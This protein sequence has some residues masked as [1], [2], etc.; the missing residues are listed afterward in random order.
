M[1]IPGGLLGLVLAGSLFAADAPRPSL[2]EV[3]KSGDKSALRDLLQKKVDANATEA[4]GTT[5][6]HW[7]AY[8]D[9]LESADLLLRAGAKVNAASDLG[10]T[11]L[12]AASQNGSS[13][14]VKKLLDAGANPNLAL[15]SGETPL[16]V[17]CRSGYPEAVELL[18]GKGANLN[19]HGTRGQTA[20]MWAVAQQHADVVKVLIAHHVDLN[21]KS[22]SW[23]DVMAVPPHGY[24]PY[25]I[26]VPQGGETALMFAARVGDLAS[27]KLL[28]AAGANVNDADAWGV[29]AVTLAE[30]S[31]FT[32]LGLF[33]L[34]KGAN[35]NAAPNGFTALHEAIM[36]RDEKMVAALLDHKADANTPL[37]QWTPTRR[38]SD[39]F[40]FEPS[41]VGA[42]PFWLAAR[43]D[44]P[45]IMRMLAAHGADAKV[46]FHAQ[47]VGEQ[48]FGQT[49]RSETSTALL[50]ATGYGGGTVKPWVEASKAEKEAQT[51]EAV[52]IAVELGVDVNA[53]GEGRTALD[54][55]NALRYR[56]VIDFLTSKG[57]K[58]GAGGG[59]GGRG[60]GRG[61]AGGRGGRG[62]APGAASADAP[63]SDSP[64]DEPK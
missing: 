23:T 5:A 35:P 40:H 20:L 7:A 10:A 55:A 30:H 26:A 4:D 36:R 61:A 46:V 25:N 14:M 18:I 42:T 9:D 1:R 59:R 2:V 39:D 19:A 48:G 53:T 28:I 17:A 47:W 37:K 51:L 33:L 63:A 50:A 64:N 29:S 60:G 58:A 57:A 15:L 43:F 27:A 21:L 3:A 11:P 13:A 8:R 12:W 34:D 54:G 31:G 41:L 49:E 22:D 44:E 62:A 45:A 52:K 32:D 16:M 24:L 56:S 38:S 6:L